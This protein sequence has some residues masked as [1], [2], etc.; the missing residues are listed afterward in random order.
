LSWLS[1]SRAGMLLRMLSDIFIAPYVKVVY[2]KSLHL[3]RHYRASL[4]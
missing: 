1:A 4:F 2:L 3:S